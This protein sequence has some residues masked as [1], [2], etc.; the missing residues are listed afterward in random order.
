VRLA[1]AWLAINGVVE[2]SR[3]EWFWTFLTKPPGNHGMDPYCRTRDFQIH[4]NRWKLVAG[5]NARR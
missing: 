5:G 1:L 4:L 2:G 3:V